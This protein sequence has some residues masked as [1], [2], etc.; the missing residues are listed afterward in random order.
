MM[1]R[2]T[3]VALAAATFIAMGAP[4]WAAPA[5]HCVVEVVDQ[6]PDGE[7][8][9]SD[10]VCF[11]RFSDAAGYIAGQPVDLPAGNAIAAIDSL[12]GLTSL[13]GTFTLGIH[14]DGLGG[15]GSSI[16]VVGSSC[17][18]GYWNTTPAWDNR[19]SSSYNGCYRLIHYPNPDNLGF[20]ESTYGIGSTS[21]LTT[22][23][24]DA[25]SISYRSS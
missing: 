2:G 4:G 15:T 10:P 13:S 11:H 24:N 6:L 20:G 19:I 9:T 21:N 12:G 7:L 8:V 16:S 5:E 25:E 23:N 3:V 14:F 22:L 1:R 18:G 17:T